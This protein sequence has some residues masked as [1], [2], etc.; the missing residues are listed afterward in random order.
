MNGY[1]SPKSLQIAGLVL[2]FAAAGFWG[3]TGKESVLIMGAA[4]SLIGLGAYRSAADVFKQQL[5]PAQN[6]NGTE[7]PAEID[8]Q[9]KA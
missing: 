2:L 3:V 5:D 1:L 9:S 7:T 4:M 8:S 6:G